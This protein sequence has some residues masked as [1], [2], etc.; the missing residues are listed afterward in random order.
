MEL[1]EI[2]DL[3]LETKVGQLFFIGLP[4]S[5][6]DASAV[7]LLNEIKP[8]GVCL[9]SRNIRERKQTR[10][11]L[12]GVTNALEIQPFLS[13]DQEGGLVDR[14][15]RIMEP[16]PA[17]DRFRDCAE[18]AHFASLVAETIKILGFNM[19]FAP[20]V[21]VV[22]EDR[23]KFQNGL[24]SRAF[25]RS[26]AQVIELAGAF[27]EAQRKAGIIGCLKHFP[28]L[29]GAEV[30]SHEELPTVRLDTSELGEFD[31]LPYRTL[32]KEPEAEMVMVAHAAFPNAD[33]Q[34]KDPDGRL[35]PSSLSYKCVKNLLREQI[36]FNGV[37][38]TDDMEMGAIVRNYGM[39]EACKM[40]FLAGEDMIAICA[41]TDAIR[42]GYHA[43]LEAVRSCE[44][45]ESLV[46]V[47]VERIFDLKRKLSPPLPF[48]E[49]RLDEISIEIAAIKERLK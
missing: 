18:V 29:G 35:L 48:S 42:E 33:L 9:F 21:D 41:G 15:R 8:G 20:V 3:P 44:I 11:L 10:R 38:I 16:M 17:A 22:D 4:G 14:L 39:A 34:E 40:A 45:A 28:G 13:L 32:L 12:D 43:V 27:L 31:L 7:S 24:Q 26:P 49:E 47:S 5:E 46:D 2:A 1:P 30:D 36:G 23:S 19:N 6:L 25:G 37:T